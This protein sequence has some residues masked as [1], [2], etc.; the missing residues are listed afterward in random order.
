MKQ[1]WDQQEGEPDIAFGHFLTYLYAGP[2]RRLAGVKK[3]KK[4]QMPSG[5]IGT[6]SAQWHWPARARAWDISQMRTHGHDVVLSFV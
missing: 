6:L 1:P 3:G 4:R 2:E 5:Y